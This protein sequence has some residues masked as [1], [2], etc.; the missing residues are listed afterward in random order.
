MFVSH[1][2]FRFGPLSSK[3]RQIVWKRCFWCF[4]NLFRPKSVNATTSQKT[5]TANGVEKILT[6][7][8]LYVANTL[9]KQHN[10]PNCWIWLP[11]LTKCSSQFNYHYPFIKAVKHWSHTNVYY[12]LN[13]F[14]CFLLLLCNDNSFRNTSQNLS[15][16]YKRIFEVAKSKIWNIECKQRK[17]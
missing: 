11:S 9:E 4:W 10:F 16:S 12:F 15:Y 7:T 1:F 8:H 13:S 5:E 14:V 2:L 17:N 6:V 3:N